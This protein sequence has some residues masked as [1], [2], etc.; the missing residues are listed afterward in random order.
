MDS[1]SPP[2]A[3]GDVVYDSEWPAAS[4]VFLLLALAIVFMNAVVFVAIGAVNHRACQSRSSEQAYVI[5][6][7]AVPSTV[8]LYGLNF[9]RR[10]CS[11]TVCVELKLQS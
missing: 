8:E 1:N 2:L 9:R 4:V 10:A 3:L 6:L 7:V 11:V 5:S